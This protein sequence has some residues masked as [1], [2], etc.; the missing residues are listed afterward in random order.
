MVTYEKDFSLQRD[1]PGK[2]EMMDVF[3]AIEK[4]AKEGVSGYYTL[5]EDS[6]M[7]IEEVE[8]YVGREPGIFVSLETIVVMGIGGSSLGTKAIHAA[9]ES[10]YTEAKN[11]FFLENPDPVSLRKQFDR[12]DRDKTLFIV[13][14]KSGSTIETTSIFKAAIDHFDLHLE[15]KDAQ[16][17][18]VITDENSPLDRF[19]ASYSIKSFHIPANV[20]GRFSVLSSVGIVPL[21]LAGYDV[22]AILEGAGSFAKRFFEVEEE[23]LLRKAR[24]LTQYRDDYPVTVLFSYGDCLEN[25]T[26]WFVQLWGESLGKIDGQGRHTGLTPVGHIGSVDQHSFLQLII[27]GMRDKTVT[28]IK[29]ENFDYDLEIPDISLKYIEKVDYVNGHTFNELIDVECDAT[30]ESLMAKKIPVDRIV[31][32]KVDEANIGELIMYYEILTSACGIM[33]NIDTYDQPGVELGKQILVK[34]FRKEAGK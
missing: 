15:G 20:G 14:S 33:M 18:M 25:F 4:E 1:E 28:F 21:M 13:V 32:G 23:H 12:I 6:K 3:H 31:L 8:S 7:I 34:K 2:A 26:K 5:P 10:K 30:R 22:Q 27:E 11:I 29:I 9:L 16:R 19:A 24:F 17:I